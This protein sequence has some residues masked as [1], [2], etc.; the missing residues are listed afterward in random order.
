MSR[1]MSL[2]AGPAGAAFS[3][4]DDLTYSLVTP[5]AYPASA[6]GPAAIY[7][8]LHRAICDALREEG[9]ETELASTAAPKISDACFANPVRDDLMLAG[10][11]IAGAAQR[12]T[13]RGFLHQGSIQIPESCPDLPL[14]LRPRPSPGESRVRK[15]RQPSMRSR[16]RAR[17]RKIWHRSMVAA[18]VIDEGRLALTLKADLLFCACENFRERSRRGQA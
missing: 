7:A 17:R 14:P 3:H 1:A 10:R 8:A 6:L 16:R 2:G 11:K 5:A 9:L 4:G 13:R 12:R 15:F 18:L